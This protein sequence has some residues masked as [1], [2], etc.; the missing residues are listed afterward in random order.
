MKNK[1]FSLL[2]AALLA[3][4]I[5]TV[6]IN[7]QPVDTVSYPGLS[8]LDVSFGGRGLALGEAMQAVPGDRFSLYNNPATSAF[9]PQSVV[10]AGFQNMGIITSVGILGMF[11]FRFGGALS[12]GLKGATVDGIEV[13][14]DP[15]DP[16]FRLDEASNVVSATPAV[17]FAYKF[18]NTSVGLGI[19][20]QTVS[21]GYNPDPQ[22]GQEEDFLGAALG[23]DLGAYQEFPEVN[24]SLGAVVQ[25]LGPRLYFLGGDADSMGTP[26]PYYF[27]A[28]ARYSLL[29]DKLMLLA[30]G[31]Y[32]AR[33]LVVAGAVEYS[34]WHLLSLRLGYNSERITGGFFEGLSAGFGLQLANLEVNYSYLHNS[35]FGARGMHG[36]DIGFHFG[37]TE[38]QRKR[39]LELARQQAAEEALERQKLTSQ[40]LYEQGLSFYNMDRYDD[41]LYNWDLALIWW[42]ENEDAR[43]M[44]N[45]VNAERELKELEDLVEQAKQAYVSKNYVALV[46]L[47]EQILAQDSAH[48]LAKFYREEAEKGYTEEL[49]S[50]APA[51]VQEDLRSGIDALASQDYLSA[52]RAF[53]KVQDFDPGNEVAFEYI[54]KTQAEIDRYISNEVEEVNALVGNS[55]YSEAKTMLHDLLELAPQNED[56]L[57]KLG[58]IDRKLSEDVQRRLVKAEQTEDAARSEKELQAVLQL[59]PGNKQAQENLAQVQKQAAKT[60]D[61]QKLYLL[62]VESYSEHNYEL[63]ISYWQRVLAADPNHANARKNLGR[64][65]AKLDALAGT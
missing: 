18:K 31:G 16:E 39:L 35:Y 55:R 13:R 15:Q 40:S 3:G 14:P 29:A 59:D 7:A 63:A 64:A 65:Q 50:S 6:V 37:A 8:I 19:R 34:P 45:K 43:S 9:A 36:I 24:L 56:L 41:A 48:S 27:A 49:I 5:A 12:V 11:P 54:R 2:K 51:A 47:T 33:G 21:L 42:P 26:Q 32:G 46:V 20:A 10:I 23:V 25:N 30:T 61:V 57:K 58:E 53:E 1:R 52:M 44:I 60:A 22:E 38:A 4:L 62:G 28:S 17:S